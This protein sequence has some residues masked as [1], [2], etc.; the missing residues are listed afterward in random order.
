MRCERAKHAL[1][2]GATAIILGDGIVARLK[3][4]KIIFFHGIGCVICDSRRSPWGYPFLWASF[5]SLVP[6][7]SKRLLLE[8]LYHL[9]DTCAESSCFLL[10][11]NDR[12]RRLLAD[13]NS[14]LETK[15]IIL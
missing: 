12:Y 11:G 6:T 4:L 2:S 8:Q 3:A 13:S 10:F 14:E 9:A 15:F 1:E 5:M 7:D